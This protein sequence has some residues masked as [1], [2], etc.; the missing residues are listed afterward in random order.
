MRRRTLFVGIMVLLILSINAIKID[1]K[2]IKKVSETPL[3][4]EKMFLCHITA[5]GT[6]KFI[7][8][9]CGATYRGFGSIIVSTI[10][11][12]GGQTKISS[13]LNPD[14]CFTITGGQRI[15]LIGC[16]GSFIWEPKGDFFHIS[17]DGIAFLVI[18][19]PIS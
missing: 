6:G 18:D 19:I 5:N 3:S 7:W 15:L 8:W 2:S 9:L 10:N 4:S 11:Y 13:I 1:G 16:I 17:I 14:K 12:Q